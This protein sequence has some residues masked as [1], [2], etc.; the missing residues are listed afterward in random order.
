MCIRDRLQSCGYHGNLPDSEIYL[1]IHCIYRYWV[2]LNVFVSELWA[3]THTCR[4]I[5]GYLSILKG[6][7]FGEYMILNKGHGLQ[8]RK[9]TSLKFYKT[10]AVSS[11]LFES[12]AL[13]LTKRD[14]WLFQS[15]EIVCHRWW[16]VFLT[17]CVRS[18]F[19]LL[20]TSR[21]V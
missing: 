12:E 19:C 4:G 7:F 9:E 11:L 14:K 13:V 21:C 10:M 8:W 5:E 18:Y 16:K 2:Y 17:R 1:L 3:D 20:Y 15:A 6:K